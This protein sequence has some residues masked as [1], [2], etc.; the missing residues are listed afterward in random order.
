MHDPDKDGKSSI[1]HRDIKPENIAI[2]EPDSSM[3]EIKLLDFGEAAVLN[4]G[5]GEK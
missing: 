1:V 4:S 5:L 3:P 2:D